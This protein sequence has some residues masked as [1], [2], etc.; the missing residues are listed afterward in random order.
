MSDPL[1]CDISEISMDDPPV[2]HALSY[3]WNG[4]SPS[5]PLIVQ[6]TITTAGGPGTSQLFITPNC[7]A[8]LRVLRKS[9]HG[10][11]VGKRRCDR[12]S[13][14]V[15]AICIDQ[16]SNED[17][18]AQVSMMADIYL[19]A[20]RVVVWLGN[21]DAPKSAASLICAAPC[22]MMPLTY[23]GRFED[24]VDGMKLLAEDPR[25]FYARN[26]SQLNRVIAMKATEPRDKVYSLRALSPQALEKLEVDYERPVTAI[27]A[28]AT[29]ALM[30][31]EERLDILYCASRRKTIIGGSEMPSWAV[32]FD[33][34]DTD[35]M[36]AHDF[37]RGGWA[38]A[39]RE[40]APAF[41]FSNDGL[42]LRL[43]GTRIGLVGDLVS[44]VFPAVRPCK[45]T[46]VKTGTGERTAYATS[47]PHCCCCPYLEV[48]ERFAEDTT[49]AVGPGSPA[50]AAMARAMH[51]MLRAAI[52]SLFV[53]FP[54]LPQLEEGAGLRGLPALLAERHEFSKKVRYVTD[55]GRLFFTSAGSAGTG[56]SG[57]E[58]GDEIWLLAGL[59][60]PFL[61]RPRA[62]GGDGYALVGSA[63]VD[64]AMDGRLWPEE[65]EDG[66]EDVEIV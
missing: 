15:D 32:D 24:L 46:C 9:L 13:V 38:A 48:L 21:R 50:E 66:L 25:P 64:C 49:R 62:G 16:T 20:E 33:S 51:S 53:D 47:L 12:I 11:G 2:Y 55:G 65:E 26:L 28:D 54:P 27:F 19:R 18:S 10:P 8:G 40:S 4:E 37:L 60:H 34:A 42:R 29:R 14:W 52:T 41:A 63:L 44:G 7:A 57:V 6:D 43:R 45:P 30:Q 31:D 23:I 17:K 35:L 22:A 59:K 3:T 56:F 61:L 39:S 58:P 1:R 5:E 36:G